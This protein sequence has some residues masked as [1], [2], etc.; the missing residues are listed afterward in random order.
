[1]STSSSIAVSEITE[2]LTDVNLTYEGDP[3]PR[4]NRRVLRLRGANPTRDTSRQTEDFQPLGN[5]SSDKDDCKIAASD[6]TDVLCQIGSSPPDDPSRVFPKE[7]KGKGR[8]IIFPHVHTGAHTEKLNLGHLSITTLFSPGTSILSTPSIQHPS[9]DE[10][11]IECHRYFLKETK[12]SETLTKM[13]QGRSDQIWTERHGTSGAERLST[14]KIRDFIIIITKFWKRVSS[15][16]SPTSPKTYT[17]NLLMNNPRPPQLPR[18]RARERP[19]H[20]N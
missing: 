7:D 10:E 11:L 1:M 5:Q 3:Q 4:R 6:R 14:L 19:S 2:R 20:M 9:I 12:D 18:P 17:T 16:Q 13:I 8:Y 15:D